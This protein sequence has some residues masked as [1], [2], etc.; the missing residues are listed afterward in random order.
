MHNRALSFA[1]ILLSCASVAESQ[2]NPRLEGAPKALIMTY[3]CAP[4]QRPALQEYMSRIGLKQ[5]ELWKKSG[6]LSGYR[7]LFSRY[8]DSGSWDM[9]T[10]LSFPD[11][12]SLSRWKDVEKRSPAGLSPPALA[13]VTSVSTTPADLT[14][15]NFPEGDTSRSIFLIIPYDYSVSTNEYV[16]YLDGYV[17]PQ[18][19]GWRKEDVLTHYDI[20]IARY[21]TAR[22]W[23]SLLILEYA[24]EEAMGARDRVI[25]K[26]RDSLKDDSSW[27]ALAESKQNVRVEK[28]AIVS[29]ELRL[30]SH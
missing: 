4:A 28:E 16:R 27:K 1:L 18:L 6:I 25:A 11:S 21:G 24:N 22:P 10:I 30:S 7:V 26:V 29:D 3:K 2:T 9:M 19:N 14:R 8:V 23:S 12:T 20:F 5:L 13:V 15:S 17:V